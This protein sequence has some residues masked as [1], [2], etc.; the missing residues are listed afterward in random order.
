[1]TNIHF[2]QCE[3]DGIICVDTM[4]LRSIDCDIKVVIK[5]VDH[6]ILFFLFEALV[7]SD[8]LVPHKGLV[9]RFWIP[10]FGVSELHSEGLGSKV[11]GFRI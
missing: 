9:W 8:T 4:A 10:R 1:M 3:Y 7:S 11:S 6:G 2:K 5:R